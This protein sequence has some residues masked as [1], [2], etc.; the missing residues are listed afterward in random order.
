M[1]LTMDVTLPPFKHARVLIFII[2][3]LQAVVFIPSIHAAPSQTVG[4]IQE[5][6]DL[7]AGKFLITLEKGS[8]KTSVVVNES[9]VIRI[10]VHAETLEAG[11]RIWT[12]PGPMPGAKPAAAEKENAV[13]SGTPP[14]PPAPPLA[15]PPPKMPPKLPPKPQMPE[16][17]RVPPPPEVPQRQGQ[18]PEKQQVEDQAPQEGMDPAAQQQ[19][20]PPGMQAPQK[21]Q[22]DPETVEPDPGSLSP[23]KGPLTESEEAP[24]E[25]IRKEMKASAEPVDRGAKTVLKKE[26]VPEGTLLEIEMG[27]GKVENKVFPRGAQL[28]KLSDAQTLVKGMIAHIELTQNTGEGLLAQSIT[29]APKPPVSS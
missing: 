17:P 12:V 29:A 16:P 24:Q 2:T 25:E 20:A 6:K 7:G 15:V 11:D 27:T 10:A 13:R 18:T 3:V 1:L 21:E 9:T 26:E 5:I 28:L 8:E 23:D 22:E 4:Q 14:S 19:S